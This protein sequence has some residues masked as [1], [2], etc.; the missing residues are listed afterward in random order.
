MLSL[1]LISD[2]FVSFR[3]VSSD[4]R[5]FHPMSDRFVWFETVSSHVGPFFLISVGS[6]WFPTVRSHVGRFRLILDFPISCQMVSR[7]ICFCT[8][9]S[10]CRH[11]VLFQ[12]VLSDFRRF[13]PS[14]VERFHLISKLFILFLTDYTVVYHILWYYSTLNVLSRD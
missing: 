10:S 3:V 1:Y 4:F 6:V 12:M 2:V 8:V 7:V 9:P 5:R 13:F 11:S 14:K